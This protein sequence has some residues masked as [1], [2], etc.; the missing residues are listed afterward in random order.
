MVDHTFV[1]NRTRQLGEAIRQESFYELARKMTA[2][3][4][5]DREYRQVFGEE[6]SWIGGEK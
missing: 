3:L 4:K 6:G 5:K 2:L 1:G